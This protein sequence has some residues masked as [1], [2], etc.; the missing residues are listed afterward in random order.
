[1]RKLLDAGANPNLKDEVERNTPLH[2]AIFFQHYK[3]VELLCER[4][5]SLTELN[6]YRQPPVHL[7]EDPTML[8]H[9]KAIESKENTKTTLSAPTRDRTER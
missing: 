5:A 3:A 9:V 4:G 6:K 1:M 7:S 2:L 8:R